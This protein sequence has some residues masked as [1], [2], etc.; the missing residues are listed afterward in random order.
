[1]Y[2]GKNDYED[3]NLTKRLA[4]APLVYGRVIKIQELQKGRF[5]QCVGK[6]VKGRVHYFFLSL[7]VCLFLCVCLFLSFPFGILIARFF[8]P[9]FP[10]FSLPLISL[11][12]LTESYNRNLRKNQ[13]IKTK[14]IIR[15]VMFVWRVSNF[16]LVVSVGVVRLLAEAG[17]EIVWVAVKIVELL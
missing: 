15:A 9:I 13:I 16:G 17:Q 1:M 14:F 10:L 3:L 11:F 7:S 12:F 5:E 8:A 4:F 6:T 2:H